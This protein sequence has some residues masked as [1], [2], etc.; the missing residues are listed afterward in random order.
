MPVAGDRH[1]PRVGSACAGESAVRA[2]LAGGLSL[3]ISPRRSTFHAATFNPLRAWP[4]LLVQ[5]S[6]LSL[7]RSRPVG[8]AR[9][10]ARVTC[11]RPAG[12]IVSQ[13]TYEIPYQ[14]RWKHHLPHCVD[15][16]LVQLFVT[17]GAHAQ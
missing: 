13:L 10:A 3:P 12:M 16:S 6:N 7:I 15:R 9:R 11:P 14:F 8:L 5:F 4:S 2:A 17:A 1:R